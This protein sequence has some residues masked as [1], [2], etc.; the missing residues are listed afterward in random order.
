MGHYR[1][2]LC[3]QLVCCV[4]ANNIVLASAF[5]VQGAWHVYCAVSVARLLCREC[6][7]FPTMVC[8]HALHFNTEQP[9]I[10]RTFP[11]RPATRL[12]VPWVIH[13]NHRQYSGHSYDDKL[14]ADRI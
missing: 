10:D 4:G 11:F 9:L 5:I 3:L 1:N 2:G 13:W 12:A 7:T 14:C 6:G 8:G